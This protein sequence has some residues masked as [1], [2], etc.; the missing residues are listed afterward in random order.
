MTKTMLLSARRFYQPDAF[1]IP[2]PFVIPMLL[3]SRRR[4]DLRSW[5]QPLR[6][7]VPQHDKNDAFV[8]PTLLS[9][10]CL[11]S[12]RRRRDLRSKC[13][14]LRC[15]VPQHDKNDALSSRRFCHPDA[16]VI[17]T[18]EGSAIQVPTAQMLR[19]SA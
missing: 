5:C 4:R 1:I 16:F 11:L 12:S 15:F 7:F 17:P 13:Q 10:R 3:S 6:C 9:S 14:P 18:Q 19:S 8:I 2:T